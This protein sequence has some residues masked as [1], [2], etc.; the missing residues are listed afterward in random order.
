[1]P[2]TRLLAA[3]SLGAATLAT[4]PSTPAHAAS[5][6]LV[7]A[8]TFSGDA[9]AGDFGPCSLAALGPIKTLARPSSYMQAHAVFWCDRNK[10]RSCT[11]HVNL[12]QW[13]N[14][15]KVW[16]NVHGHD[17][18]YYACPP[19][20]GARKEMRSRAFKCLKPEVLYGFR[21]VVSGTV[22][23]PNGTVENH[24]SWGGRVNLYC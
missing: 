21:T 6:A 8:P 9:R 24:T 7:D 15:H 12:Q 11:F 10:P 20:L 23:W 17:S 16:V 2:S 22:E 1:M 19:R 13:N 3:L 5:S 18:W 4:V 14:Y